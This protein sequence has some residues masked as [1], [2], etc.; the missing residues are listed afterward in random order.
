MYPTGLN[1]NG[2]VR[3]KGIAMDIAW[4]KKNHLIKPDIK[5][6]TVVDNR[7]VDFAVNILGSY[8]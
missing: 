3:M 4:Y 8:Q 5:L 1:P 2:Y 6:E 7:Y